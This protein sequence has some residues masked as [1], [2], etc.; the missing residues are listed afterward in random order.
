MAILGTTRWR[1]VGRRESERD[2]HCR[3]VELVGGGD[4]RQSWNRGPRTVRH[5]WPLERRVALLVAPRARNEI[6]SAGLLDTVGT[7]A[8]RRRVGSGT[9]ADVAWGDG[10]LCR[11]RAGGRIRAE[12]RAYPRRLP[13]LLPLESRR[14]RQCVLADPPGAAAWGDQR[15]GA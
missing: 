7:R 8:Q 11:S 9:A 5:A 15:T 12:R 13:S 3:G 4:R 6:R 14:R 1:E 2:T 10:H